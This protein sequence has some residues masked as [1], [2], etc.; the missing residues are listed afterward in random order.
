MFYADASQL[1]APTAGLVEGVHH[2][3]IRPA[4]GELSELV[5]TVPAGATITD[6][7]DPAKPTTSADPPSASRQPRIWSR[8]GDSILTFASSASACVR[9]SRD[10]L[11]W[12]FAANGP[13]GRCRLN[14][15]WDCLRCPALPASGLVGLATGNETQVDKVTADAMSPIN[16]E[17]FPPA[18]L[19]WLQNQI[20][21]L[22]LRRAYRA[23]DTGALARWSAS[24]VEPDVRIE[25]QNTLSLGEDRTVLALNVT[26]AISRAGIFRLSFTLPATLELESIT[27][28]SLSHWTESTTPTGRIITLHLRGKTGASNNSS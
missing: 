4:H 28:E 21:G 3:Q 6:V 11:P 20:P 1:Y 12:L 15:R 24:A 5:F 17:D 2:F 19:E 27:G 23:L 8:S 13:P 18:V 25:T 10:R 9:R 7:L 22:T 14:S 26:A 16:I